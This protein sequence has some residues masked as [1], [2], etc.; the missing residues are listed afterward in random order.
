MRGISPNKRPTALIFQN[1]ALFPLMPVWE[2]ITFGLKVRGVGRAQRR[3]R[4]DELLQIVDLPN[5]GDKMV[6]QLSGGQKQRIAIARA[7]A[8]EP[9]VM[10]LDEP[11]SALDLK[12]RQHMRSEL[13]SIQERTG[14]TFIYITHDQSEAL[15]MS[16]RIGV[17]SRGKLQQVGTPQAIYNTPA[18]GFVAS[19]VGENTVLDGK[20]EGGEG[21]FVRFHTADGT[22]LA[23]PGPDLTPEKSSR[24]FIR[25]E[26]IRI[27]AGGGL[28][29]IA[30]KVAIVVFEGNLISIVGRTHSGTQVMAQLTNRQGAPIPPVGSQVQFSFRPEGA[31][32]LTDGGTSA[33][34]AKDL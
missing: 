3:K 14:V 18:N 28:N 5:S 22:F 11:L 7:L 12:L 13:R 24:L 16:D 8:V 6:S 31:Q 20:V 2:N 29:E 10:L 17:M 23:K 27:D 9:K 25:P 1:L 21:G 34:P 30:A 32:V 19:F 4:A 26:D 33:R 15:A